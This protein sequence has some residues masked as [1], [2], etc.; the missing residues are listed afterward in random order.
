MTFGLSRIRE[1][2][3]VSQLLA[4]TSLVVDLGMNRGHFADQIQA[5]FGCRVVGAEPNPLLRK[6]IKEHPQRHTFGTAIG[7]KPG[8]LPFF[9]SADDDEASSLNT[10]SNGEYATSVQVNVETLDQFLR[11]HDALQAELIK[12]DIE[13]AEL[14]VLE[15]LDLSLLDDVAQL[16]V[17][18][19]VFLDPTIRPRIV[20]LISRFEAHGYQVIDFSTSYMDVLF[21]NSRRL[22]LDA[23][24]VAQWQ[25]R[26]FLYGAVRRIRWTR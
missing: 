25:L 13:G 3:F 1:H 9:I 10:R 18:F 15:K 4:P 8:E 17:E 2:T 5:Q 7:E 16:S 23:L 14:P 6:A 19:H 24:V 12:V 22:K 20:N 11:R 26:K 21:V